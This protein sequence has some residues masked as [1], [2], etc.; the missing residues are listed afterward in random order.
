[1]NARQISPITTT[2]QLVEIIAKVI[3]AYQSPNKDPATRTFQAIRIAINHELAELEQ[4]LNKMSTI[5]AIGGRLAVISFH[6]LEDRIVKQFIRAEQN[7]P[8]LPR[9]LPIK[10][11]TFVPRFKEVIKPIKPSLKE[12]NYN[13][14]ARSAI[15]RIT[16][17]LS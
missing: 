2:T 3:P 8:P 11:P 15:L 10:N 12:V 17:K 1:M 14:R 6:S 5:L 9:G 16:E 7:G 13:P 4:I